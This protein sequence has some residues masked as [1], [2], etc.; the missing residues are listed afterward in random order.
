MLESHEKNILN[1]I[2]QNTVQ[3]LKMCILKPYSNVIFDLICAEKNH[4]EKMSMPSHIL[5]PAGEH[6]PLPSLYDH[7]KEQ[8]TIFLTAEKNLLTCLNNLKMAEQ[9]YL[10]LSKNR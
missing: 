1:E 8:K 10:N 5:L 7:I 9:T 6:V 4:G 2:L 3:M